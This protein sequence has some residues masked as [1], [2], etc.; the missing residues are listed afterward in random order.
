MPMGEYQAK[1]VLENISAGT[2]YLAM[3]LAVPVEG[4]QGWGAGE[5]EEVAYTGYARQ[6]ISG[7]FFKAPTYAA[8]LAEALSNEV[9]RF[10]GIPAAT[11]VKVK[12]LLIVDASTLKTG[13]VLYYVE[14]VFELTELITPAE[15]AAGALKLTQK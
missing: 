12:A 3:L 1:K 6:K 9:L 4:K 11:T 13:N 7:A 10:P 8:G 5:L 2:A 14:S 15:A